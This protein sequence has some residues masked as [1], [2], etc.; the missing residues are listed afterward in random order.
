M[1][2]CLT[3][4]ILGASLTIGAMPV[5]AHHSFSAE[6]DATLPVVLTG[7]VTRVMRTRTRMARS[8]ST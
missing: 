7:T 8:S 5:S 2:R 3:V 6:F 4:L 1:S